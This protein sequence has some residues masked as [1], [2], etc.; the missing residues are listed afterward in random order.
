MRV[1]LGGLASGANDPIEP[2]PVQ[3]GGPPILMGALFPRA[4]LDRPDRDEIL[5]RYFRRL[6]M[7]QAEDNEICTLQ[8][9]GL[10]SP[11]ARPGRYSTREALVHRTVNWILDRVLDAPAGEG[12]A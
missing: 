3:S 2:K 12:R 10:A 7:T 11:L 9:R 6:D 5:K 8:H 4:S 1:K